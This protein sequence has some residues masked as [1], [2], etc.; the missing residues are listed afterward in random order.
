MQPC[1][2]LVIDHQLLVAQS[3]AGLLQQFCDLE[4]VRVCTTVAEGCKQIAQAPPDLLVLEQEMPAERWQD[5]ADALMQHNS[6]GGLVLLSAMNRPDGVPQPYG[7]LL[8]GQSAKALGAGVLLT[9]VAEWLQRRPC[10]HS[11]RPFTWMLL[12]QQLDQLNPREHRV[13]GALG[14]GWHNRAIA[15]AL[16]LSIAT[17]ETYRKA[18]SAKL[19]LS[20]SELVRA[21]VLHRCLPH[22]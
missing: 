6:S 16:G 1:S 17:V 21:A 11:G 10:C 20:G 14:L 3:I 19:G 2:I 7:A 18:I 22:P 4:R 8:V 12:H 9:M 13:F 5:A 15:L